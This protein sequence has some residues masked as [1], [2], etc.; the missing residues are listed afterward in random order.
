MTVA[1]NFF[2]KMA[3]ID[4]TLISLYYDLDKRYTVGKPYSLYTVQYKSRNFWLCPTFHAS[5]YNSGLTLPPP[6]RCDMWVCPLS[7]VLPQ[8][9]HFA[10]MLPTAIHFRQGEAET[11]QLCQV[12]EISAT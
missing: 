3:T 8:A 11:G 7:H 6:A 12:A 4:S 1:Q 5:V 10:V 2:E 9:I